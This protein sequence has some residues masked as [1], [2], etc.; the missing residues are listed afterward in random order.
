MYV[1]ALSEADLLT[2]AS[3]MHPTISLSILERMIKFTLEVI[4]LRVY[5]VCK[6]GA[7]LFSVCLCLVAAGL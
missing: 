3:S 1:D 2:I 6:R 7:F 4:F 5:A